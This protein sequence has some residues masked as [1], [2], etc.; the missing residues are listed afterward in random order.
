MIGSKYIVKHLFDTAKRS[1]AMVIVLLVRQFCFS[2]EN[3][4]GLQG[5]K[6]SSLQRVQTLC[7]PTL[8][9][10]NDSSNSSTGYNC[11]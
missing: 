3:K 10:L 1:F 6:Y 9:K 11:K 5:T 7:V 8:I 4:N 2:G